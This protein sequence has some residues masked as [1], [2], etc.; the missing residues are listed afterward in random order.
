MLRPFV[1]GKN[2]R[3]W[4]QVFPATL[5]AQPKLDPNCWLTSFRVRVWDQK[6]TLF[7]G[8]EGWPAPVVLVCAFFG[9]F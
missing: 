7:C 2:H 4:R 3:F 6:R 1:V 8:E 9:C 5:E